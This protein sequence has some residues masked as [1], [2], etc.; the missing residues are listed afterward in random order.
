MKIVST[1][2]DETYEIELSVDPERERIFLARIGDRE[3]RLELIE[4][5]PG[6]MTLAIDGQVGFYEFHYD[7]GSMQEVMYRNRSYRSH[8]RN[9]QQD[10]LEKLLEQFGAGVGGSSSQT[11]ITA[12]MPG[13]ILGINVKEGEKVD[14]GQ[15]IL[16][17]EAM[18]MENEIGSTVEGLIRDIRVKVGDTVSTGDVLVEIHPPN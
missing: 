6:S 7:K 12:P 11:I 17:L 10:Q 18:K 9:P 1:I 3:V 13:K 16:I 15:I 2:N 4:R 8:V 14:F 5:K